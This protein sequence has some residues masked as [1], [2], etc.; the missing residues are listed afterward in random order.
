MRRRFCHPPRLTPPEPEAPAPLPQVAMGPVE[1][2]RFLA[3]HLPLL[4]VEATGPADGPVLVWRA[5][6]PRRQVVAVDARA[7]A[8]GIAPRQNLADARAIAPAVQPR[9]EDPAAEARRLETLG[10]WTLRFTPLVAL[11]PPQ[12]LLLDITGMERVFGS[13]AAL[14]DRALAGLAQLGHAA[15]AGIAGTAPLAAALARAA[16]GSIAA[17]GQEEAALAP[18]PLAALRLEAPLL[19][20]LRR[21]GLECLGDL[22]AQ[23]RAPLARRVGPALILALDR[24]LGQVAAPFPSL[25]P[26]PDFHLSREMLEPLVTRAGIDAVLSR[27]LPRLCRRL[28]EAGRGLRRLVLRAHRGDATMQEIV[29]G[30]GQPSRDPGHLAK[31]LEGRLDALEPR[32]GFERLELLAEATEP[33]A[34]LQAGM[35]AGAVPAADAAALAQLIDRL[36]QRLPVWRLAPRASHWPERAVMKV[37][38]FATFTTPEGWAARPRPLRLLRKPEQIQVIAV[39]PDAP[40]RCIHWRGGWIDIRAAEG[41]ERFEPEWWRDRPDRPVRDYYRVECMDGTRL[42]VCRAGLPEASPR[43]FLHGIF[44]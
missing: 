34:A 24:M 27:L 14:R 15:Q 21:L 3:L 37:D 10:L 18:L 42:W 36:G 25:R 13:E 1:G 9:P 41:P 39:L 11:D 22:L 19:A 33:L 40:P 32:L 38:P 26:P 4:P 2:R 35:S 17:T 6:G 31:L 28:R 5:E 7:A 23:P 8:L 12:G 29:L 43:W 44:A 16:P 30:L 20:A